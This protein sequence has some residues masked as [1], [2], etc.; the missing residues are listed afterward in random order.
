MTREECTSQWCE[1]IE[2]QDSSG[3]SGAAFCREHGINLSRFY[4]WRRRL[5]QDTLGGFLEL[6]A[7]PCSLTPVGKSA[8]VLIHLN[9]AVCIELAPDFDSSAL[10]KA[11]QVLSE[12]YASRMPCFP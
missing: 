7:G 5:K 12:C 9:A 2:R 11:I 10:Q 6:R 3:L 1:L 8:G 4:Y